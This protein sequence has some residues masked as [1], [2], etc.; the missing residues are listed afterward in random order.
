MME[1]A[2]RLPRL[3]FGS[4]GLQQGSR[5]LP[6]EVAVALS[7]NGS[8]Q[9]VMMATPADLVDFAYGFALTEGI[10]TPEQIDSVDIVETPKGVDVQVWLASDAEARLSARRRTMAGPVGCGLC[11]IDSIDQA[12]RAVPAVA[13]SPLRMTPAQVL[14]AVATLTDRQPLHDY[15]RAAHCAA[16]WTAEGIVAARED[17]GRHNALDKLAGHVI[18]AGYPQGAVVL[19]SR[20]SIDM[21]QKVAALGAPILIAV[22]APTAHAVELADEAGITLIALARSD[23]FEVFS[24]SDRLTEVS[25]VR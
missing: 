12:M 13:P 19:T 14:C 18:R 25:H 3:T 10:A 6:E 16:Y 23:R 1:T 2:R 24:H 17:V 21:V 8:T 15:T 11:G 20:V 9:A 22:S 5:P 7:F 4:D